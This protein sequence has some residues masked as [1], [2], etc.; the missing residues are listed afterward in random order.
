M[1]LLWW[2]CAVWFGVVG[3]A[4]GVEAIRTTS[5]STSCLRLALSGHVVQMVTRTQEGGCLY[6]VA[7]MFNVTVTS[8]LLFLFIQKW[9]FKEIRELKETT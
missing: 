2:R 8:L 5:A 3:Y 7:C 6:F 9:A 4:G 1:V